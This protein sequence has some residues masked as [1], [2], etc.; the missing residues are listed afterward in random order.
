MPLYVTWLR[1]HEWDNVWN[2]PA[3]RDYGEQMKQLQ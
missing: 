3:E 2:S 1:D